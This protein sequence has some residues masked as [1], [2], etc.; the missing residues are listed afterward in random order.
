MTGQSA[1]GEGDDLEA[2][3]RRFQREI[4]AAYGRHGDLEALTLAARRAVAEQ[5]RAPWRAG[6]PSMRRTE[7]LDPHLTDRAALPAAPTLPLRR[8]RPRASNR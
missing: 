3:I 8:Q 6:G 2:G 1:D 7:L 5:V 4:A